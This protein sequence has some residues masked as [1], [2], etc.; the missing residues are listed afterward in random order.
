MQG[1]G[2]LAGPFRFGHPKFCWTETGA[3][4]ILAV[5]QRGR[6]L[7]HLQRRG[8]IGLLG[9]GLVAGATGPLKAQASI[10]QT[11]A[12]TGA[13]TLQRAGAV[14]TLVVG[15][16]LQ[17]GDRVTTGAAALASL[18]LNSETRIHLGQNSD[19]TLDQ[20]LADMGGVITLGGA[21]VFDR[22]DD[23][24]PIDLTFRTEFGEIGVRGTRFF[25]GPSK[26]AFAVFVQ[27]GAVEVKG[28]GTT[29]LLGPG[30][31]VDMAAGAAPSEVA[32]WKAPRIEAAFASVGQ[33]P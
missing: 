1:A 29:R 33:V 11:T 28:G 5:I 15:A 30:D 25:A 7:R 26:A 12:V 14:E 31:G 20:F 18:L 27:R 32:K 9:A 23:L 22:P 17:E 4:R 24:A 13:G 21:M 3:G 16:A 6:T 19:L 10:G 8:F 2:R